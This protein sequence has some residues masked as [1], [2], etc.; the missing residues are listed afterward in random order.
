VYRGGFVGKET[1]GREIKSLINSKNNQRKPNQ[2]IS[3][4]TAPVFLKIIIA[5]NNVKNF[6]RIDDDEIRYWVREVPAFEK[7][8]GNHNI[9][10]DMISEIPAFLCFLNSLP[11]VDTSRSRMVFTEDELVTDALKN[12]KDESVSNLQKDLEILIDE[13]LMDNEALETLFF[14]AGD[15]KQAFFRNNSQVG[16]KYISSVLKDEMK[17]SMVGKRRY[18]NSLVQQH[19]ANNKNGTPFHLSNPYYNP[20]IKPR[21]Y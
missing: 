10:N 18:T 21:R 14:S 16:V 3:E 19:E 17:L 12:V 13:F 6:V 7:G 5:S 15:V 2:N 20:K 9:L 8:S 4:Y 1:R 11:D